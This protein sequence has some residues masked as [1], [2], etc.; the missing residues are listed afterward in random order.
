MT[1]QPVICLS[2]ATPYEL[3]REDRGV[4]PLT[5]CPHCGDVAWTERTEEDD[6]LAWASRDV[7]TIDANET[8]EAARA[9][10]LT[11][12]VQHLVVVVVEDGAVVGI[13]SDRDVLA[14]LSPRADGRFAREG[15]AATLRK[16]AHQVMSH[17]LVAGTTDM[18][19]H[20]AAATLLENGIHCLP[21]LADDGHC[22]G[23]FS[24][25]DALRWATR[26][27]A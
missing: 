4:L 23:V 2:C 22:A 24:S 21:L 20:E 18:S 7:L 16:R 9:T 25:S 27:A 5:A 3:L 15:D 19:V 13:I 26:A 6:A 12:H 14:A 11:A 1:H 17:R 8:L 10:M